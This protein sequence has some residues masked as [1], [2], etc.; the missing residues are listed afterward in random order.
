MRTDPAYNPHLLLQRAVGYHLRSGREDRTMGMLTLTKA[1]ERDGIVTLK[2]ALPG[3]W[4]DEMLADFKV[5]YGEAEQR[6]RSAGNGSGRG[7]VA[8]GPGK[9]RGATTGRAP[10]AAGAFGTW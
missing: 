9:R 6:D 2:G 1:I 3:R 7:R 5:L 4:A 8:R 10:R